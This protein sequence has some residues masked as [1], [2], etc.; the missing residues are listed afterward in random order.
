MKTNHYSRFLT[1][2]LGLLALSAQAFAAGGPDKAAS[3]AIEYELTSAGN[4]SL[5]RL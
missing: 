1:S 5:S 2:M 3:V 4:V